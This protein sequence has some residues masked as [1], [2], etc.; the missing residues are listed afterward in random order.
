MMETIVQI[1][2]KGGWVMIPLAMVSLLMFATGLRLV[3][4]MRHWPDRWGTDADWQKWIREPRQAPEEVRSMLSATL[5]DSADAD[6]LRRRFMAVAQ[7]YG[8]GTDRQLAL[9]STLVAAGP[10]VGLLGTVTGMLVTFRALALGGG[11]Q[12]TEAM[13]AGISQALFPPEVGLCIALPGMMMV[14][15]ARRRRHELDAFLARI[16]SLV[17]QQ[18]RTRTEV[19]APVSR[20]VLVEA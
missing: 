9:L 18:R 19:S 16:E 13:A 12:I 2:M 5:S 1:W 8:P 17:V 6:E 7:L 15:W 10:L 11:G 4:T 14:H 3:Q 20:P